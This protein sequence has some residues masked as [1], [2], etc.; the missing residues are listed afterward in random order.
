MLRWRRRFHL[1]FR[2]AGTGAAVRV[3]A[4]GG[5][6]GGPWQSSAGTGSTA[7]I[8]NTIAIDNTVVFSSTATGR[9]FFLRLVH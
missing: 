9:N 2:S 1:V 8:V 4:T 6:R 5:A 7:A 3:G